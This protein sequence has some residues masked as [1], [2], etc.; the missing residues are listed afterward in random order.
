MPGRERGQPRY[1][2]S[3][4]KD[5]RVEA[6][7]DLV[8]VDILRVKL[9]PNLVRYQFSARDVIS[10]FDG[11]RAYCRQSSFAGSL[12][13]EYLER[14]FPLLDYLTPYEYYQQ[15]LLNHIDNV[16]LTY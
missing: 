16:S 5:Y 1:A 4:P 14:K 15:W 9:L 11:L 3:I 12:F 7:G 6:P 2:T 13:L 8:E 10:R